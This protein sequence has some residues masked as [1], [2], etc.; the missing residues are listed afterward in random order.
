[1]KKLILEYRL[2]LCSFESS[3]RVDQLYKRQHGSRTDTFP[4]IDTWLPVNMWQCRVANWNPTFWGT[5]YQTV[6]TSMRNNSYPPLWYLLCSLKEVANGLG[7]VHHYQTHNRDIIHL[8][9]YIRLYIYTHESIAS[10]YAIRNKGPVHGSGRKTAK[11]THVRL[12]CQWSFQ[13]PYLI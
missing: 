2:V 10:N 8:V 11:L 1:M 4:G 5:P 7:S 12:I 13:N 3:H 6:W 9:A